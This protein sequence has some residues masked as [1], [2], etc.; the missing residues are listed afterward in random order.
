MVCP[1]SSLVCRATAHLR[2]GSLHSCADT[3]AASKGWW[4]VT[5]SNRRHSA[6]KADA[7]PTELT[8]RGQDLSPCR[9]PAQGPA[10]GAGLP[11]SL[12]KSRAIVA[13][14]C[15]SKIGCDMG[16]RSGC[17]AQEVNHASDDCFCGRVDVGGRDDGV[18]SRS[19]RC[20][21]ARSLP[22][23]RHA[24]LQATGQRQQRRRDQHS[25]L[26]AKQSGA[27]Q[28]SLQSGPGQPRAIT[29][30]QRSLRR[31][32][33]P[34]RRRSCRRQRCFSIQSFESQSTG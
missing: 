20:Q 34:A 16:C 4:A 2:R 13:P 23:R 10:C 22:S 5:D 19:R 21:G 30:R 32:Q 18:G 26:P 14:A 1:S 28:Q 8:A 11:H 29:R 3:R 15:Q 27:N 25:Q 31:G 24:L 7:L 33:K 12:R 6:C 17:S 9:S